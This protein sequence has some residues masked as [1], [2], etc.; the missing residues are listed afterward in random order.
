LRYGTPA[1]V[2]QALNTQTSN[3]LSVMDALESAAKKEDK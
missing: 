3:V 1:G 2:A